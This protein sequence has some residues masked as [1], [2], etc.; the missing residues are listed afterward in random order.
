MTDKNRV[1]AVVVTYEPELDALGYLLDVLRGQVNSVVVVDNGSKPDLDA[2]N[3][4]RGTHAVDLIRLGENL[5]IAKAQNAGIE[6]A[7]NRGAEFV[8]LM[9]QDSVPATDM[10][11]NLLNAVSTLEA[12]GKAVACVGPCYTDQRQATSSPFVRMERMKIRHI[13]C[14]ASTPLIPVDFVISSGCLIPMKVLN[15]VGG[16]QD[17]LFIDYVDVEWGLRARRDGY[18][19][20]GVY[21]A[22]MQHSLGGEP[23]RFFGRI[24]PSHSPLRSYYRFRNGIYLLRQPWSGKM[25]FFTDARRLI[26]LYVFFAFFS[27]SR[28]EHIKMMSLGIWHSFFGRMGRFE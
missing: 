12:E 16:M 3:N 21:A 2:W 22:K 4:K 6:W 17:D 27:D 24:F 10:V 8:L 7:K 19:S 9:D 14:N 1:V 13:P 28:L 15:A 23:I 25:W 20:Y 5:G 26:L 11:E 18:Q